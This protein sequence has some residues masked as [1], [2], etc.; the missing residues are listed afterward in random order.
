[1]MAA[2]GSLMGHLLYG[3]LLGVIAGGAEVEVAHA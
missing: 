2:A 3:S 1:M